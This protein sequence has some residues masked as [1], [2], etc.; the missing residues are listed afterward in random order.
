MEDSKYSKMTVAQLK[1]ECTNRGLDTTG[2]KA[3]LLQRIVEN[4][5]LG[6]Y[7][8]HYTLI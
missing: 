8:M 4:Q 3:D 6:K 5:A 7:S 2:K 1:N